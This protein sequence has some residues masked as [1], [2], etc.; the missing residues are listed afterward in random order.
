M[1]TYR[2]TYTATPGEGTVIRVN[3]DTD[4]GTVRLDLEDNGDHGDAYLDREAAITLGR[5]L[6]DAAG[7]I[8]PLERMGQLNRHDAAL[9]TLRDTV[10][11]TVAEGARPAS[12]VERA[13]LGIRNYSLGGR[14]ERAEAATIGALVEAEDQGLADLLE[15]QG[16]A[17]LRV[18]KAPNTE[19]AVAVL[20]PA[21]VL[22]RAVID[23]T[24][25]EAAGRHLYDAGDHGSDYCLPELA[26]AA[27][28]HAARKARR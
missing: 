17:Y 12:I 7:G 4:N 16:T 21:L 19:A 14:R 9:R 1:S 8:R 11:I 20:D 3:R 18:T 6:I 13:L 10:A 25:C 2:T 28:E 24:P 23:T 26:A 5:A 27:R 22:E 15:E